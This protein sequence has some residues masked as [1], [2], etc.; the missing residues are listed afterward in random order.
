ML[1]PFVK[2]LWNQIQKSPWLHGLT[3]I[4]VALGTASV[5]SIQVLNQSALKTFDASL[6][7]LTGSA[8]I[9][10]EGQNPL[11]NE[12]IWSTIIETP[13]V[14]DA[15]PLLKIPGAVFT[16]TSEKVLVD[17]V[18]I[19]TM[20]PRHLDFTLTEQAPSQT[21][22]SQWV[23]LPD[24]LAKRLNLKTQD[25]LL[26]VVGTEV[27]NLTLQQILPSE[28]TRPMT[29][30]Q[31]IF[32]DIALLQHKLGLKGKISSVLVKKNDGQP[33]NMLIKALGKR[34]SPDFVLETIS[35]KQQEAASLLG[36]FRLNLSALSMI[37]FFV[38]VFLIWASI[39]ASIT[40]RRQD[41]GVMRCLG[42]TSTQVF[43]MIMVET[44]IVGIVGVSLG[45][46][47]GYFAAWLNLDTVSQ[48]ISNVY[49]LNAIESLPL[50][51]KVIILG[52]AT[53]ILGCVLGGLGPTFQISKLPPKNLL[54]REKN[55]GPK[56]N[57]PL[58]LISIGLG[59]LFII[60]MAAPTIRAN[61]PY[62]GFVMAA[63]T[64]LAIA[65]AAPSIFWLPVKWYRPKHLGLGFAAR[66]LG[67]RRLSG[68]A[69]V[70][71]ALA[72][73]MCMT[74]GLTI[75]IK[76]FESTLNTWINRVII[77]DVYLSTATSGRGQAGFSSDVIGQVRQHPSTKYLDTL[78]QNTVSFRQESIKT[79]GVDMS[80]PGT[81][82]RFP[83]VNQNYNKNITSDLINNKK[84]LITEPLARHHNLKAGSTLS[85]KAGGKEHSFEVAAVFHDYSSERGL[86]YMDTRYFLNIFGPSQPEG[87]AVYIKESANSG[88]TIG[89]LKKI[90]GHIPGLDI[91]S[92]QTLKTQV[93]KLFH[94][95][96][97]IT[98]LLQFMALVIA[99]FGILLALLV[100]ATEEI[101]EVALMRSLGCLR[102]QIVWFYLLKGV[103]IASFAILLGWAGGS[104][105]AYILINIMNPD[106][107]GWSLVWRIPVAD[108]ITNAAVI[109]LVAIFAAL[110][111]ALL[112]AR[113]QIRSL[114]RDAL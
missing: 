14:K 79:L 103:V 61:G 50:D 17:L 68:N 71:A 7:T 85:F 15:W 78:R 1:K 56:N 76:S 58:K 25:S 72:I 87:L 36:A 91:R 81:V 46:P 88:D 3:I 93:I 102:H 112:A 59:Q 35:Q 23:A 77:A 90:L 9:E 97:A 21:D 95:T 92:N 38:G 64:L 62:G 63:G 106:F 28:T 60:L 82:A 19:D 26:V 8:H 86:I 18:G 13:G 66:S 40:Q 48:T 111:P 39:Q 29:T 22:P 20:R 101:P 49:L 105:L 10:V 42:M 114:S 5:I 100:L 96:F 55:S 52:V 74:T 67:Q 99:S 84:V 73:T 70:L 2:L 34:L 30:S 32:L 83:L 41:L 12:K 27:V 54:H 69:L 33:S 47:A 104:C 16:E 109:I 65:M 37:S 80:L 75:M 4:G 110:Y 31:V 98:N 53:G 108:L 6:A 113:T 44:I 11:I 24:K 43:A 45:L 57:W 107:F 89:S 51:S 94:Q